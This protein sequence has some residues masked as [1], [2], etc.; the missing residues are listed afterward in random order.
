MA[1][2]AL[3]IS[4]RAIGLNSGPMIGFDKQGVCKLLGVDSDHIPVMLVV[5]GR[6]KNPPPPRGWRRPIGEIVTLDG[7][8]GR[9]LARPPALP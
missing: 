4:A 9:P 5:L 1:A 3:M 6:E 2:M 7:F 8:H